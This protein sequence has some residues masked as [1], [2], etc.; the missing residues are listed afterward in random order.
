ML[1]TIA[2]RTKDQDSSTN[3]SRPAAGGAGGA[4]LTEWGPHNSALW[5]NQP[6]CVGHRLHDVSLFHTDALAKLIESYPREYYMLIHMGPQG[7]ERRSWREGD[8]AGLSGHEVLQAISRG[9][10]WLNLLRTNVV[11]KRY[12][13]MLDSVFAE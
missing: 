13:A 4:C 10:L 12:N 6:V 5:Y 3:P 2:S 9:R 1:E 7:T 8:L 11:D